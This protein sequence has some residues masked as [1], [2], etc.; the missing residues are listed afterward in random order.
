MKVT[1]MKKGQQS[2]F[3][4]IELIVVI[5]VLGILAATALPR[6][7]DVSKDARA[8]KMQAAVAALNTATSLVHAGWLVQG[9]PVETD[10]TKSDAA[11]SVVVMEGAKIPFL[12]GYP[13]VGADGGTDAYVP[14]DG[15]DAGVKAGIL[16][17]AGLAAD[18]TGAKDYYIHDT[19]PAL[20]KSSITIYPDAAHSDNGAGKP[21]EHCFVT[22]TE[23]ASLNAK[24]TVTSDLTGC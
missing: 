7:L 3:T 14:T 16:L 1:Q 4:L 15:A 8:A 2:G 20:S 23:A 6:F 13:D 19:A 24:P 12:F 5:V 18:N 21:G 9:S 17:A 11:N 10:G 22:Y